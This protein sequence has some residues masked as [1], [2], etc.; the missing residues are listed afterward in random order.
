MPAADR[1]RP[2]RPGWVHWALALRTLVP[3]AYAAALLAGLFSPAAGL[4]PAALVFLAGFTAHYVWR[5]HRATATPEPGDL[6]RV[7]VGVLTVL[8]LQTVLEGLAVPAPWPLAVFGAAVVALAP[9]LPP[10]G[11]LALPAVA[12][13]L[14]PHAFVPTLLGLEILAAAAGIVAWAERRRR[15]KLRVAYEKLQRDAATLGARAPVELGGRGGLVRIDETLFRF[16]SA[17]KERVRA[18]TAL[19][20]LRSGDGTLYIREL[21]TDHHGGIREDAQIRLDA[22]A[23]HWIVRNEK[24]LVIGDLR[25]PAAR[26]GYYASR[27]PVRSFAGVPLRGDG[28]VQGVL[29]VDGLGPQAFGEAQVTA[30]EVAAHLVG[31]FL[32][33][34]RAFETVK[35]EAR[36]FQHLHEFSRRVSEFESQGEVLDLLLTTLSMRLGP[37]FA[38][39]AIV[40]TDRR[41]RFEAVLEP[42]ADLRGKEFGPDE[43]LAGWVLASRNYLHYAEGRGNTRRPLFGPGIRVP[44]FPSLLM[45]PMQAHGEPVGVL[46]LGHRQP[47][48]FDRSAV[49]F[50]D[51]LAQLAG[52]ALLQLRS[53]EQ[54]R[55]LATRDP[56]TGLWNRRAFLDRLT[57]ELSRARRYPSPLALLLADVDHFKRVNDRHGHPAGD[58]VLRA[59]AGTLRSLARET[60]HVARY[61]GEEFAILLPNTDETGA[62]A[63]A[64]RIRKALEAEEIPWEG[65]TLRVTAS[66]G[67]GVAQEGD[68]TPD[69]LISRADQA[70][71]AAKE[72][73]RNRVVAYSDI[74]EYASWGT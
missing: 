60:D 44:E 42:W 38:A 15:E 29:A 13:G 32:E 65:R 52:Q 37:P 11:L 30:L 53:L 58:Q 51:V 47:K 45:Y 34:I 67:L 41:L 5:L 55:E 64:E 31:E 28:G 40:G 49:E 23:F 6:D 24:P 68:D 70:L 33:Q 61:G 22:T 8:A 62:R 18:H 16:L 35:R 14:R 48:A 7:E 10:A 1:V 74:R 54:L 50:A 17:L 56:L 43:G 66:L 46:C 39:V 73:G 9:W 27:V 71:Y 4:R 26:L 12:A 19:L 20:V 36:D 69:A 2:R 72:T 59:V 63:L 57:A 3:A 25:D 21:V